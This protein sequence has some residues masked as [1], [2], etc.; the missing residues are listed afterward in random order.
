MP[1][2]TDAIL[3]A[4]GYAQHALA[5]MVDLRNG[6]Q[7]GPTTDK[8]AYSSNTAYGRRSIIPFL[9]EIPTG[10]RLLH[11]PDTFTRSLK[12]LV[13]LHPKTIEG[14]QSTL[15]V[16]F[17]SNP[18]GG[19][20]EIQEDFTKVTRTPS[21][22]TFTFGEKYGKPVNSLFDIWIRMLMMDPETN[23]AGIISQGN[24][25]TDM[26]A[27]F[28]S[29]SMLFVEPD[30]T[31]TYAQEAWLC[32]NMKPKSAGEVVGSRDI[33]QGN[34]QTDYSIEFTAITQVGLGV[35][36]L[37]QRYLQAMALGGMNPHLKPAFLQKS[38]ADVASS[39]RG[40][41]VKMAAD[42]RNVVA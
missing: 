26:L 36:Q 6:A 15:S 29:M 27:D 10:F 14:L 33:T 4:K 42:A 40:Y 5:P 25:P 28:A 35:K 39:D 12:A 2:L 20:G 31:H 7:M 19:A 24:K 17:M 11:D 30:P 22:P 34:Q 9:L 13:E 37:G 21:T 1:R 8:G 41:E 32:T 16:E 3:G 23:Y 38:D 18:V